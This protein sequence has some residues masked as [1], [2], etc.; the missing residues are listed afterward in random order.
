MSAPYVP[1]FVRK[2][3]QKE[4]KRARKALEK[5]KAGSRVVSKDFLLA[6]RMVNKTA[7]LMVELKAT[8]LAET[9]EKMTVEQMVALMVIVMAG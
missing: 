8:K 7:V 3:R 5:L 6:A 2:Q 9:M 1:E 4:R